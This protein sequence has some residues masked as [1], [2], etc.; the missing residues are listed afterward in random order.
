MTV[1]FDIKSFDDLSEKY[2]TW[3]IKYCSTSF[4]SPLFLI[5]YTDSEKSSTNNLLTFENGEIFAV[6]SLADIRETVI[7]SIDLLIKFKNLYPWLDNFNNL[8]VREFTTY[9]IITVANSI[10]INNL[11]ILTIEGL[12]NYFNLY[13]DF[14]DQDENNA[15]FQKISHN[16]VVEKVLN[17]FY[18]HIFW[19]RFNDKDKFEAL[20]RPVL[21][22]DTK[23]LLS[24]LN[25]IMKAFDSKIR[26][27]DKAI[28]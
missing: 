7:A 14:V 2:S 26:L 25:E 12:S 21:D 13:D 18:N 9:D 27:I 10:R 6:K 3:I 20:D 24:V 23:K 19:P 4:D 11:D 17:Y 5:W 15:H 28:C 1:H 16:E 22:I 8:E